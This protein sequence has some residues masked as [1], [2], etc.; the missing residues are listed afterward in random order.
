VFACDFK[1]LFP[2]QWIKESVTIGSEIKN[3]CKYNFFFERLFFFVG[4]IAEWVRKG[5]YFNEKSSNCNLCVEELTTTRNHD[6]TSVI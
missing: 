3:R 1:S 4:R 5:E 2:G 6:A